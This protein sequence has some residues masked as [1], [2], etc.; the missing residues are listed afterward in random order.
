MAEARHRPATARPRDTGI[1]DA[2]GSPGSPRDLAVARST[3]KARERAEV[4]TSLLIDAALDLVAERE[5]LEFTVQELVDRTKLSLH[6]FYQLFESKDIL[7]EAVLEESLQRGVLVLRDIVA[8]ETT[9]IDRLRA[10]VVAYFDLVTRSSQPLLGSGAAFQEFRV[11]LE[12]AAP[13]KSWDAYRPLRALMYD[14]LRAAVEDGSIRTDLGI[15]LVAGFVL[16]SMLSL[17]ELAAAGTAHPW[18][19]GDEFWLLVCGG[20]AA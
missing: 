18:P 16:S 11:H 17:T 10:F 7:I 19:T 13:A 9:P 3:Q 14:L 12:V 5:S 1:A 2:S 6:A 20:I 15:D 8:V 4:R